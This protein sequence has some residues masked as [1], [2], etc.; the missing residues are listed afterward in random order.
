MKADI[1]SCAGGVGE[2]LSAFHGVESGASSTAA[3]VRDT[4]SIATAGAGNCSLA[5]SMPIEDLA[6]YQVAESLASFR[7]GRVV[8]GLLT[9]ATPD[10]QDVQTDVARALT[11]STGP[12]RR[13]AAAALHQALRTLDAQRRSVDTILES[14]IRALSA[15]ASLPQLP[16]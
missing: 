1:E 8:S 12:G 5:N 7:L 11:A 14:A 10:A 6:Q 13:Q 9:W 4:V 2:S 3:D 15:G 16:G